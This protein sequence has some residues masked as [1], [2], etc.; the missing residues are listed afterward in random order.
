MIRQ[1]RNVLYAA[2]LLLALGVRSGA[3]DIVRHVTQT[4]VRVIVSPETGS[5]LVSLVAVVDTSGAEALTNVWIKRVTARALFGGNR[6]LSAESV[7]R[8]IHRVGGNLTVEALP[9]CIMVRCVTTPAAFNDA[10]YILMQALKGAVFDADTLRRASDSV[11]AEMEEE[12]A[13]PTSVGAA[14]ARSLL[15]GNHRYGNR[16]SA[17]DARSRAAMPAAVQRF[18]RTAFVPENTVVAIVG[19]LDASLAVRAMDNYAVDYDRQPDA[20]AVRLG[21]TP[22]PWPEARDAVSASVRTDTRSA[23]VI[24]GMQTGG[25]GEPDAAATAVLAALIGGGKASR[26]FRSIRDGSGIGYIIGADANLWRYGGWLAAYV[27]YDARRLSS[28]AT[29]VARMVG[30]VLD[31]LLSNPPDEAELERA[32]AFVVGSVRRSRERGVDVAQA[33]AEAELLEG[34]WRRADAFIADV[35]KVRLEDVMRV[36]ARIMDRRSTVTVSGSADR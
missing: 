9:D 13:S 30:D 33:L 36:A 35:E 20:R 18:Y 10:A 2:C 28:G 15:F 27:E 19:D 6:N 14:A 31:E 34:D 32:R 3:D 24:V 1:R 16:L 12:A 11:A 29:P 21:A 25:R 23:A 4:G 22:P 8:E 7:A 5:G 17:P 26:M